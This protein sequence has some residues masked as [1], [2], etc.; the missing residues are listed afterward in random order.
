MKA[1]MHH[2]HIHC[3]D[4]EGMVR[5]FTDHFEA[6]LVGSK[7]FWG[8]AGYQIDLSGVKINISSPNSND[9]TPTHGNECHSYDHIGVLVKDIQQAYEELHEKGYVFTLLPTPMR[10]LMIAYMK[11]PEDIKIEL[12]QP[13]G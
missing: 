12:L 13:Q 8:G 7:T 6:T 11:G 2:I 1:E 9:E 3:Q 5:F 4:Q 10:N